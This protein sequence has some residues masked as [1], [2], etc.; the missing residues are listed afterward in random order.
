VG[1]KDDV[2]EL[3]ERKEDSEEYDRKANEISR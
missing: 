2:S 1:A 3:R